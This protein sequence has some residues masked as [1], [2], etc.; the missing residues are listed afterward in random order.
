MISKDEFNVV[1]KATNSIAKLFHN[2]FRYQRVAI[3]IVNQRPL[4]EHVPWSLFFMY[5][6]LSDFFCYRQP[7][8]VFHQKRQLFHRF[9]F[10]GSSSVG[11][12]VPPSYRTSWFFSVKTKFDETPCPMFNL[13]RGFGLV[14][15]EFSIRVVLFVLLVF[16]RV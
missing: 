10:I 12:V 11:P 15:I 2:R 14:L 7:H 1:R 13:G 5:R 9:L 4:L 3:T 16:P 8:C 6:F